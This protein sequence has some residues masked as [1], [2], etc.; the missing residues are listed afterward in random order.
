MKKVTGG[1]LAAALVLGAGTA[2]LAN[3]NGP[4]SFEQMLPHMKSMHPDLSER[5]LQDMYNACH[6]ANGE[7]TGQPS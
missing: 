5:Q 6:G 2:V 1:L 7:K 4:L 3:T